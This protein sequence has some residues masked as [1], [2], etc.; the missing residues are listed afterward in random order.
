MILLFLQS[1][2]VRGAWIEI[3]DSEGLSVRKMESHPVRGAWIEIVKYIGDH[4]REFESHPVRGAWIEMIVLGS[5]TYYSF[6]A[7]RKGCVD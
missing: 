7:S 1:H 3:D 6:V 2:P 4:D 5:Q